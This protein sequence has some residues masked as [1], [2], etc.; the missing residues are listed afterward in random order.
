MTPRFDTTLLATR[1]MSVVSPPGRNEIPTVDDTTDSNPPEGVSKVRTLRTPEESC[2]MNTGTAC[3]GAP[4]TVSGVV[5]GSVPAMRT[6]GTR[7]P[8]VNVKSRAPVVGLRTHVA[9]PTML[10]RLDCPIGVPAASAKIP[11][12]NERVPTGQ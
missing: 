6:G 7:P 11:G 12:G 10:K 8:P 4:W 1:R 2:T 9:P 5:A 3:A